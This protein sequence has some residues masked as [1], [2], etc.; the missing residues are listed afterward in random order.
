MFGRNKNKSRNSII[1]VIN[2]EG[3]E[4]VFVWKHEC[5][6]FNTHSQLI[7][8]ESQEAIFFKNGQ[9]L[10]IFPAGRYTLSTQ[11]IPVLK[12]LYSLPS[13]GITPFHCEVYYINKSISMGMEWGTDSPVEGIDPEYEIP[14]EVVGHGDF[15]VC[16]KDGKKLLVKLVGT[17]PEL[18]Q[19]NI[20][21]KFRGIMAGAIRNCIA[22]TIMT[23][24]ISVLMIET[25][26]LRMKDEMKRM[27]APAFEEYGL[28]LNHFAISTIKVRGLEEIKEILKKNKIE[29]MDAIGNKE[30]E[31]IK[32]EID[33]DRV[34]MAGLAEAEVKLAHG[35]AEGV[36]NQRKGIKEKDKR[37]LDI[38]GMMAKNCGFDRKGH[39]IVNGTGLLGGSILV[40]EQVESPSSH[41]KSVLSMMEPTSS[42]ISENRDFG[43]RL[44]K[45][46]ELY[47]RGMI[48]K[49]EYQDKIDQIKNEI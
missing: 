36:V 23:Q 46:K 27:M 43:E 35:S 17:L 29:K 34:R 42:K 13:G 6:D 33:A 48:S 19:K 18:N 20:Q 3:P 7:V 30:V 44:D 26:L 12:R 21:D 24:K 11:N 45:L 15:S 28:E 40:N 38:A 14:V 5:E 2:Y 1:S 47:D 10:D 41:I 9:A 39:D 37:I 32:M 8:H 22:D 49:Q 4:E 25:K 31:R 16:V